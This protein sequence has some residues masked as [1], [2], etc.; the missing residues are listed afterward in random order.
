AAERVAERE[1]VAP[2]D[3]AA[4]AQRQVAAR[5]PASGPPDE[6][7][8][9]R[10]V[11]LGAAVVADQRERLDERVGVSARLEA[12]DEVEDRLRRE[13]RDRRAADM[14][15]RCRRDSERLDEELALLLEQGAPARV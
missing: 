11:A 10:E 7:A 4:L 13:A 5:P 3:A 2:V 14:L 8:P 12:D 15:D 6:E 1:L 9:A